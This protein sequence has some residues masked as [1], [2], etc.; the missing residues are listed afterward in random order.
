MLFC[1]SEVIGADFRQGSL[2][3]RQL[4]ASLAARRQNSNPSDPGAGSGAS[5]SGGS[6]CVS[7]DSEDDE[8][9]RLG[10]VR[11][12]TEEDGGGGVDG[13]EK[14][15]L[16]RRDTPHHLKNKRINQQV[17]YLLTQLEYSTYRVATIGVASVNSLRSRTS[18][19]LM[20]S[21]TNRNI[22]DQRRYGCEG[23]VY[24]II[25]ALDVKH[26]KH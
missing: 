14:M 22:G 19:N 18:Y 3:D 12:D 17:I 20:L 25:N 6:A 24:Y 9:D 7:R 15:R 23:S 13:E 4:P 11:F 5:A 16:H 26:R 1:S 2:A 10:A 21:C 8:G